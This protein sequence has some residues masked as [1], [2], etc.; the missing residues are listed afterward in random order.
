M[1]SNLVLMK[2][3]M[4]MTENLVVTIMCGKSEQVNNIQGSLRQLSRESLYQD[5]RLVCQDGEMLGGL[6]IGGEGRRASLCGWKER[7]DERNQLHEQP[8]DS[9]Q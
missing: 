3:E 4:K 9:I 1:Q 5:M 7:R 8:F 2:P 6:G